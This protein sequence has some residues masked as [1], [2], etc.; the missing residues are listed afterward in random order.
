MKPSQADAA[1]AKNFS[2]A[3]PFAPSGETRMPYDANSQADAS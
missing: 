2:Q 1:T 3:E